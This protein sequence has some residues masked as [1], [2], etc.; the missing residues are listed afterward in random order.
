MNRSGKLSVTDTVVA[1]IFGTP[2]GE[3]AVLVQGGLVASV[4]LPS[5][6][7]PVNERLSDLGVPVADSPLGRRAARLLEAYWRGEVVTFDLPL[8]LPAEGSFRRRV[9]EAAARIPY[10]QVRSYGDIA[11]LAGSCSGARAV[12][13]IMAHNRLP[14]IIPCHRVVGRD[15]AMTGYTAP[16]GTEL[17]ARLLAME[18]VPVDGRGRVEASAV[19]R[20]NSRL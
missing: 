3:G 19:R 6:L 10:G 11:V 12:G 17:K 15:G 16:G 14:I 9:L 4:L 7:E 8:L 2:D 20:E 18:G 1:T 13:S 5:P